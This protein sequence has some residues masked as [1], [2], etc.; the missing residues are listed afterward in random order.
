MFPFIFFLP[1]SATVEDMRAVPK[2]ETRL[3]AVIV[4]YMKWSRV[5]CRTNSIPLGSRYLNIRREEGRGRRKKE[6]EETKIMNVVLSPL[7]TNQLMAGAY[8]TAR[9][10]N[11]HTAV[12]RPDVG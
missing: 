5:E 10:Y 12:D 3:T 9:W 1:S 8:V 6:E 7:S 4:I 11:I 2:R